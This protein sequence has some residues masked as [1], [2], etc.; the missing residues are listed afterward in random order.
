M[1]TIIDPRHS[2]LA[3][4]RHE[5]LRLVTGQGKYTA[6]WQLPGQLH[7][8]MVRSDRA[9]ARVV[10]VEVAAAIASP[11]VVAVLTAS[12]VAEAGFHAIPSG[13]AL[14]GADGQPQ[15][16]SP[17]PLLATDRVRFVGQPIAMVIADTALAARDAAEQVLVDYEELPAVASMQAALAE[18]APLLH[19]A[20]PGNVGLVFESG[21][22][23]AVDAAFAKAARTTTLR[24]HSQRLIGAPM[25][26]RA[27][28]ATYDAE[29]EHFTVYTPTQGMLGMRSSL[30][31]VTGLDASRIEVV[32]QDVGG[33]FGLRGG[34]YA[35]HALVMLAARK[36]GR[37][38]K[39]VG[40]RS[41]VFTSDWH[42][43]ALTIE[44]SVALD[45]DNHILA[46]RY[47]NQADLGAYSC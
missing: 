47:E 6:D 20:H 23:A 35:E 7:A 18:G 46:F 3:A 39:W 17:L 21:N 13:M 36:L 2:E 38:V 31:A 33:S 29:R 43:R 10:S 30:V 32:A 16:K 1:N 45:A 26:L 22:R 37:P 27:C 24:V 11:G 34:P 9:H 44:A 12:D 4:A 25:E 40:S 15:V 8:C 5:D 28:L 42:G 14:T 41:E 19:E